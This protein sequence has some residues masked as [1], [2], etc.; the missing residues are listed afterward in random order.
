VRRSQD[1]I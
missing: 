1:A